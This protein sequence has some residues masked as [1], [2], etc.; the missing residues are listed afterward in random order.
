MSHSTYQNHL[1]PLS[2]PQTTETRTVFW[3][4][5]HGQFPHNNDRVIVGFDNIF[6]VQEIL[7]YVWTIFFIK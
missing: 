4:Q 7:Q 3:D 6:V 5:K 1:Q 2:L